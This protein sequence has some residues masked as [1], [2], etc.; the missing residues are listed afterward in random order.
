MKSDANLNIFLF[1]SFDKIEIVVKK[2]SSFEEI[3]KNKVL[4]QNNSD[5]LRLK[6]LD[7]FLSEN[8]FK[9]EKK[10]KKFVQGVYLVFDSKDYIPIE[11]S[12]KKKSH[13]NLIE[14]KDLVYSLKDA[15]EQCKKTLENKKIIHTVI[16][17]YRIDQID[18]SFFPKDIKCDTIC[19]D[20]RF[21]CIPKNIIINFEQIL[22]KYQITI[23]QI[24][25]AEY[26]RQFFSQNEHNFFDMAGKIIDG[27]NEN[28]VVFVNKSRKNR[29]FF[30]RFFNL[31]S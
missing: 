4:F 31:F 26:V 10:I 27:C 21:I 2:K 19:L 29:G 5:T 16:E 6:Y 24:V 15:K 23:D 30:E 18:Y 8:V 3:Y 9:I 20:V 1:I 11:I 12:I 17:N 22:K 14:K 25:S 28:E 13:G 7:E